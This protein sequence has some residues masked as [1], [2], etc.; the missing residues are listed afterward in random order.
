MG[1]RLQYRHVG[2]G[3]AALVLLGTTAAWS[4][5]PHTVR[6]TAAVSVT[7]RTDAGADAALLLADRYA[8]LAGS[9]TTMRSALAQ[10]PGDL[11]GVDAAEVQQATEVDRRSGGSTI[12]I[13]V[14]L[15]DR[16]QSVAAAN[17]IAAAL[18]AEGL[19]ED[20]V[21]VEPA[22]EAIPE[23]TAASPAATPWAAGGVLTALVLGAAAS[24]VGRRAGL[25]SGAAREP[26]AAT[27][28]AAPPQDGRRPVVDDLAGFR[29]HP[30]GSPRPLPAVDPSAAARTP[31]VPGPRTMSEGRVVATFAV[32]ALSL[33]LAAVVVSLLSR[34]DRAAGRTPAGSS[35]SA[36]A[37]A[38]ARLAFGTVVLRQHAVGATVA[39]PELR[40]S[41]DGGVPTAHL[42]LDAY[43]C[44]TADSPADPLASGCLPVP[45]EY[46]DATG[47]DLEVRRDGDTVVVAGRFASHTYP[48]DSSAVPTG[49]VYRVS[50][51][52]TATT[53]PGG[54]L[55]PAHGVLRIDAQRTSSTPDAANVLHLPH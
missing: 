2:L 25:P 9:V 33:V 50:A 8:T 19:D 54:T 27:P 43:N 32:A 31:A 4:A 44:L 15:P 24:A 51:T 41:S 13:S 34:D 45:R 17:A 3:V 22:A 14:A 35:P 49:H 47:A 16:A 55:A 42:T 46:A 21:D 29:D 52:I 20:L 12:R 10:Q 5:Q 36:L 30:P 40:L 18:V 37:G 6:A 26:S 7:P 48:A 53:P 23:D 11:A 28:S 39:T 38:S 1:R